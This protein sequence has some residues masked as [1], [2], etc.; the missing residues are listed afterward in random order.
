MRALAA[1]A[2]GAALGAA[3]GGCGRGHG[4]EADGEEAKVQPV[5]GAQTA[6]ALAR[7]F[8]LTVD[9]IGTV[10]PRPGSFAALGA[11][12]ATRVARIYVAE[13]DAVRAGAPLIEFERAPFDAEARQAEARRCGSLV[14]AGPSVGLV[15]RRPTVR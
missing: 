14:R 13:G 10:T 5:V 11:P 4:A 2:L 12:A 8:A 15:T 6:Q 1:L 7:P 3:G 9:A